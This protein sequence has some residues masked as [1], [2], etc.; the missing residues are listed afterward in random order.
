MAEKNKAMNEKVERVIQLLLED[1]ER[2]PGFINEISEIVEG[3]CVYW[4][5]DAADEYRDRM[6][7]IADNSYHL[8]EHMKKTVSEQ[9]KKNTHI[10]SQ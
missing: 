9:M 8:T 1:L 5:G 3:S 7:E 6:T 2:V 4:G 10:I